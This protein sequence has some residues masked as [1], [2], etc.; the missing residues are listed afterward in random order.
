MYKRQE[1]QLGQRRPQHAP[2]ITGLFTLEMKISD[3]DLPVIS[4]TTEDGAQWTASP[5][6]LS[7]LA[8]A[9][10]VQ[11]LHFFVGAL[12]MSQE[13]GANFGESGRVTVFALDLTGFTPP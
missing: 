9:A 13:P 2:L 11:D 3:E 4:L 5:I 6:T 8:F 7:G 1:A 10:L 12:P